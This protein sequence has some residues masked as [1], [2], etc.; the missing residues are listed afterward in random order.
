MDH[1]PPWSHGKHFSVFLRLSC[2]NAS[3]TMDPAVRRALVTLRRCIELDPAHE[4]LQLPLV[5]LEF[6]LLKESPDASAGRG[7]EVRKDSRGLAGS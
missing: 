5:S 6:G 7:C 4:H 2:P 3:N 1:A